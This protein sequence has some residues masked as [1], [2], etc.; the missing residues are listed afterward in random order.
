MKP[1]PTFVHMRMRGTTFERFGVVDGVRLCVIAVERSTTVDG[2][3]LN[4][5]EIYRVAQNKISH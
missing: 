4:A 1:S 3:S 2:V 5:T